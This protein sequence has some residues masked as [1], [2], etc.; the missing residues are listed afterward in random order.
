MRRLLRMAVEIPRVWT[1][2]IDSVFFLVHLLVNFV[3]PIALVW[4]LLGVLF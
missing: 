1:R 3:T 2:D 4:A